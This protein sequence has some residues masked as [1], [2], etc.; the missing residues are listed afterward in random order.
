MW[1]IVVQIIEL[2]KWCKNVAKQNKEGE[3]TDTYSE[4]QQQQRYQRNLRS[5]TPNRA[6][7]NKNKT[8]FTLFMCCCRRS[9]CWN[10]CSS[11]D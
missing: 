2:Q 7:K 6:Y 1:Q 5:T 10:K 11:I 4:K 8:E 9:N 3:C